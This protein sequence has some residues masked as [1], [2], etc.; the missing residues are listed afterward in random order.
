MA[1]NYQSS[2]PSNNF[3]MIDKKIDDVL[4]S[5]AYFLLVKLM[6]L[7]PKESNSNKYLME[8]TGLSRRKFESAKKELVKVG[9]LETQQ[10]WG[11]RYALYIGSE[12]V[13]RYKYRKKG[14]NRHEQSELR[15]LKDDVE[16]T[17]K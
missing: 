12:S 1:L 3:L 15:K 8:K 7:A 4:S 6:K 16:T 2:N 5:D 14:N 13:K 9:Y 17:E 10:L 11:N